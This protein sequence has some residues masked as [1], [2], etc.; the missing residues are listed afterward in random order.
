MGKNNTV[1]GRYTPEVITILAIEDGQE[2]TTAS[3]SYD[4]PYSND[5]EDF[6]RFTSD[7]SAPVLA[8]RVRGRA[9]RSVGNV[10]RVAF[11]EGVAI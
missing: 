9:W 4:T 8:G 10:T 3:Q 11:N 2:P 5:F 6:D 1:N 7:A